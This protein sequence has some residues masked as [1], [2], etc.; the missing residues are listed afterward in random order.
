MLSAMRETEAPQWK[1]ALRAM[2]AKLQ[3]KQG[4]VATKRPL[5][6]LAGANAC[7][8]ATMMQQSLEGDIHEGPQGQHGCANVSA[9]LLE[10]DVSSL[11]GNTVTNAICAG[12]VILGVAVPT[13]GLEE[14]YRQALES[15]ANGK[16]P[17]AIA[18]VRITV[19]GIERKVDQLDGLDL[20]MADDLVEA[21]LHG[22]TGRQWPMPRGWWELSPNGRQHLHNWN[23]ATVR[24]VITMRGFFTPSSHANA[25]RLSRLHAQAML[26]GLI[27]GTTLE[28]DAQT[29]GETFRGSETS[30]TFDHAT[31]PGTLCIQKKLDTAAIK[32][33]RVTPEVT[34]SVHAAQRKVRAGRERR[35][36][37]HGSPE[38]WLG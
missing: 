10:V 19:A 38:A 32:K 16:C 8:I 11:S 22:E 35:A 25:R 12:N 29:L 27:P 33:W 28:I 24:D 7:E 17:Y 9:G 18:T 26:S 34:A 37:K 4:D 15:I 1:N 13:R 5:L 36:R 30:S 14:K 21:L 23:I 3:P 20:E 2:H 6:A 31:I